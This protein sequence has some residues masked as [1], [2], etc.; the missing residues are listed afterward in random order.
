MKLIK[1]TEIDYPEKVYNLHIESDHNYIAENAVVANCH[2]GKAD[3]LKSML[4][5]EMSHVPIRWGMTGTLPKEEWNK[6][7]IKSVIGPT[8]GS[9]K[10]SEL[11]EKGVLSNCDIE[12]TQ[13]LDSKAFA[14]YQAES[15]YLT[16]DL[17]RLSWLGHK[18]MKE[19]R[20]S[21][22]TLILVN[23]IETGIILQDFFET[24]YKRKI[25][26]VHGTTNST[27]RKEHYDSVKT[28]DDTIIIATFGVAST[29]INMP[30]LFNVF[31]LEP[32]KS[33]IKT[34]QSIGRGLR[35]AHDK[36]FVKIYDVTSD[37]K[38]SKRHM[39]ERRKFYK[40]AE[41]PHTVKKIDFEIELKRGV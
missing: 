18:A 24:Y 31:M 1:K 21:G 4:S 19:T 16:S 36:N 9:I 6:M 14:T 11:M 40:E 23:K 10:A 5:N 3:A 17:T 27:K 2:G 39:S 35:K 8:V 33:F 32:G 22:N 34:I 29:G 7:A 12:I 28:S 20:K 41:Y 30:R 15:K 13:L 26:F 38:Y 37:C 25:E